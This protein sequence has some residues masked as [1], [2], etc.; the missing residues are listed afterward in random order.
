MDWLAIALMMMRAVEVG[1]P[2]VKARR[3]IGFNAEAPVRRPERAASWAMEFMMID[4]GGW[5]DDDGGRRMED[6]AL[7]VEVVFGTRLKGAGLGRE[8]PKYHV[9]PRTPVNINTTQ[10]SQQGNWAT[11]P[12]TP[13]SSRQGQSGSSRCLLG[14]ASSFT[15]LRLNNY[16]SEVSGNE[17]T[18]PI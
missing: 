12:T 13:A 3:A 2:L 15:E 16:S 7:G 17:G 5:G 10:S 18:G 8:V 1:L 6:G 4:D 11:G 9:P 14:A